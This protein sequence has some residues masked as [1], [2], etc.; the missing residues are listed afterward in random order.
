[1][2]LRDYIL[3][4]DCDFNIQDI[5]IPNMNDEEKETI[6]TFIDITRHI[7]EIEQLFRIFRVNIKILLNFY[8]LGNND[9]ISK[10]YDFDLEDTDD[11]IINFLVINYISS[12]KTL[13]ESIENFMKQFVGETNEINIKYNNECLNKLYDDVF[14]YRLLLRLRD[15]TQHGHLIVSRDYQNKYYFDIEQILST[16]HFNINKKLKNEMK[17]IRQEIY[18]KYGD[19]WNRLYEGTKDNITWLINESVHL[20]EY[21]VTI[22]GLDMKTEYYRRFKKLDMDE[23]YLLNE[24]P[25]ISRSD[26]NILIGHDPDYFEEYSRWGADLTVSGH[27]HGGLVILPFLG[28]VISPMIRLF[29]NHL[30]NPSI[31]L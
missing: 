8:R 5:E 2:R 18:E 29:P 1:M 28:G 15:F 9:E 31:Y 7:Q 3:L 17:N 4:R 6:E 12:A 21:N 22:Y 30:Y 27:V 20:D 16:P 25:P 11:Y 10:N 23:E 13:K 26:Y 14:A 24:L 19:M